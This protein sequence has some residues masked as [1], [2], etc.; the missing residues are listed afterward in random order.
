MSQLYVNSDEVSFPD[1]FAAFVVPE[2]FF[3]SIL[4]LIQMI[5]SEFGSFVIEVRLDVDISN[6]IFIDIS[7]CSSEEQFHHF[8]YLIKYVLLFSNFCTFSGEN[9]AALKQINK[10]YTSIYPLL[11]PSLLDS[12]TVARFKNR[13]SVVV[14][15]GRSRKLYKDPSSIFLRDLS[16]LFQKK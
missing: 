5:Y 10:I 6:P 9:S 4:E 12:R 3:V 8:V 2:S 15:N 1:P 7:T 16:H 14:S 13:R 11:T